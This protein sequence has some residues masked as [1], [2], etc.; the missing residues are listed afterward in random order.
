VIRSP[1]IPTRETDFAPASEV[2]SD[3]ILS[4]LNVASYAIKS[5][6]QL[7]VGLDR[8]SSHS[9]ALW[10]AEERKNGHGNFRDIPLA[11]R[12]VIPHGSS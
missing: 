9:P 1:D 4:C 5:L 6:I 7:F 10:L 2:P 11:L 3:V 8:H 12:H